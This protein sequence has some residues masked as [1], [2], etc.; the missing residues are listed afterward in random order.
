M[1]VYNIRDIDQFFKM[2]DNCKGTVELVTG[3][4]DRLNLKSKLS[5]YVAFAEIFSNGSIPE[6]EIVAHD[7]ADVM[8]LVEYLIEK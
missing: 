8:M 4:G 1:K 3:E 7:P 5:Q 2:I 6:M